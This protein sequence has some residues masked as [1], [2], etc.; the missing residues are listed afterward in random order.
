MLK[1]IPVTEW[2][3]LDAEQRKSIRSDLFWVLVAIVKRLTLWEA[4]AYA[5]AIEEPLDYLARITHIAE[6]I[7]PKLIETE[8]LEHCV[9]RRPR[10][11]GTEALAHM[12]RP[13]TFE[14]ACEEAVREYLAPHSEERFGVI[15]DKMLR[16]LHTYLAYAARPTILDPDGAK[17][18]EAKRELWGC[19]KFGEPKRTAMGKAE[20]EFAQWFVRTEN[21]YT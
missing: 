5:R 21:A 6:Q 2:K 13:W 16:A 11:K 17:R 20:R 10:E 12:L 9:A 1:I 4:L 15:A 8:L 3:Q 7:Q 14:D 19:T 18:N